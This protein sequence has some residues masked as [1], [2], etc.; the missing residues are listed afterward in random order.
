MIERNLTIS[1]ISDKKKK[2][3][4]KIAAE[5]KGTLGH[6]KHEKPQTE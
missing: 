5:Y 4:H 1:D 2:K 6:C 3:W